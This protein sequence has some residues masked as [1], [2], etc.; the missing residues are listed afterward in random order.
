[1]TSIATD[2]AITEHMPVADPASPRDTVTAIGDVP[3]RPATPR[4]RLNH[5]QLLEAESIHIFREVAC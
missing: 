2:S 5:I 3:D 1:M 4:E